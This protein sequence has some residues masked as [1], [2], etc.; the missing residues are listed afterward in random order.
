[1]SMCEN[2]VCFNRAS[3]VKP[4]EYEHPKVKKNCL[5]HKDGKMLNWRDNVIWELQ[6]VRAED[7]IA[8]QMK[9]SARDSVVYDHNTK[10]Q[11]MSRHDSS[12]IN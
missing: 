12:N 8:Q 1:M 10:G 3:D 6:S 7:K 9:E 5:L 11:L 2:S 4:E